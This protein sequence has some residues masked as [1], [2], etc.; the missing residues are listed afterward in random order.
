[1][2]DLTTQTPAEIDTA[3]AAIQARY[4]AKMRE[5]FQARRYIASAEAN[6]ITSTARGQT[7]LMT[8]DRDT[9]ARYT[10]KA[11]SLLK[12]A[13]AITKEGTPHHTEFQR[14]GGWFRAWLVDNTSGH[15]HSSTECS[16]CYPTTEFIW[17][18]EY[19]GLT[20]GELIA[21]ARS[22]ACTICFPNAP[23]DTRPGIIEA[24]AR[25][26]ARLK[27][28]AEAAVRDA[29]K[30]AKGIT[31]PD[32]SELLIPSDMGILRG[33]LD[34]FPVQAERTAEIMAVDA[35]VTEKILQG[36]Y[37]TAERGWRDGREADFRTISNEKLRRLL[38]ALAHK[39]GITEE[40]LRE[41]L[42]PKVLAKF[43]KDYRVKSYGH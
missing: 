1:M 17:L 40:T 43:K 3:L 26:A 7:A 27:R 16:T 37:I 14:R 38:P 2:H 34:G 9:I 28:E 33:D 6:L 31:N 8:V 25:K 15:V 5:V 13:Q 41:N 11:E 36:G 29:A 35:L 30:K 42:A 12:E 19:S 23:V 39:R 4:Y 22:M 32:G 21:D 20:E 10:A 24:P 18:P